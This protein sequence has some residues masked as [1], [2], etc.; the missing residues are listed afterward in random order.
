MRLVSPLLDLP[1]A[2][3]APIPLT[4]IAFDL[5]TSI[6]H[7]FLLLVALPHQFPDAFCTQ[8]DLDQR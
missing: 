6:S 1:L 2:M 5:D 3:V 8:R 4:L 7:F